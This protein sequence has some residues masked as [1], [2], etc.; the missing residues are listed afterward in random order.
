MQPRP[1]R[2]RAGK[3][4]GA[5]VAPALGD[6]LEFMRAIWGVSHGFQ[7]ASKRMHAS[8]GITGPQRLVVRVL[9]GH[10]GASAGQLAEILRLHP[11]TLTGV[12][13][14]LEDRGVIARR[15]AAHDRRQ[16]HFRLTAA[17]A[18]IDRRHKGTVEAA[19]RRGLAGIPPRSLVA[20]ERVLRALEAALG[21]AS[22]GRRD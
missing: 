15:R 14:R 5:G 7:S 10:P 9:G 12:L 19:V 17:G 16:M 20:A 1:R 11:S 8:L 4:A 22:G 21:E 6:V 13:R 18:A 3:A 2:G